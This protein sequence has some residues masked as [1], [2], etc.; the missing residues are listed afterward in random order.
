MGLV[1]TYQASLEDDRSKFKTITPEFIA[2]NPVS[3]GKLDFF[4]NGLLSL[5][6]DIL[7]HKVAIRPG[8]LF[9]FAI[10]P[11]CQQSLSNRIGSGGI[12]DNGDLGYGLGV[13][14]SSACPVRGL[15][16]HF[17]LGSIPNGADPMM[18]VVS[19]FLALVNPLATAGCF[20]FLVIPYL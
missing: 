6:A 14:Y 12:H 13:F 11:S 10:V 8:H 5:K 7:S 20:R 19:L 3:E 1:P 15:S 18:E 4:R 2:T 9:L 17:L 16:Y